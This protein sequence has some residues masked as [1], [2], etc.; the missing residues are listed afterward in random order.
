[1]HQAKAADSGF[2]DLST[3]DVVER[4]ASRLLVNSQARTAWTSVSFA[5]D[6]ASATL[7]CCDVYGN[8]GG[9]WI[10]CIADQYGTSG[11]F[12]AGPKFCDSNSGNF[13]LCEN[14]PCASGHHPQGADCGLIGASGVG[15]GPTAVE[16]TTWGRIKAVFVQVADLW[17][18]IETQAQTACWAT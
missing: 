1:M 3:H 10:G 18:A 11:D 5:Y 7:A 2:L 14:S 8:A 6:A 12:S 15:C 9:D 13:M 16:C 17:V 4:N